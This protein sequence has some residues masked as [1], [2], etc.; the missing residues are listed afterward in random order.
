MANTDELDESSGGFA[1]RLSILVCSQIHI[2]ALAFVFEII[3]LLLA[4]LSLLFGDLD[5]ETQT[6]LM[7][8]FILLG[9][10]TIPTAAAILFCTRQ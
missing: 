1:R 3:M 2:L 8:D 10:V 9:I 5:T 6:V 4:V 7:L